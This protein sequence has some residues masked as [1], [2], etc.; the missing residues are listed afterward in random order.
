MYMLLLP[1]SSCRFLFFQYCQQAPIQPKSHFLF[2]KNVSLHDFYTMT[3]PTCMIIPILSRLAVLAF[4]FSCL[5]PTQQTRHTKQQHS[6][7]AYFVLKFYHHS[8]QYFLA[9]QVSFK[10]SYF[11][12]ISL[13]LQ[14]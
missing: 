9:I 12:Q 8:I 6:F 2:H 5:P 7:F 1:Q 11:I 3:L 10:D 14:I 4:K 13:P